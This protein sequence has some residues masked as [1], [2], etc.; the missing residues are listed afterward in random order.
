MTSLE[1]PKR[2]TKFSEAYM[3]HKLFLLSVLLAFN[4]AS[5]LA[6]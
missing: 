4:L 2:T 5:P 6:A 3:M 1:E